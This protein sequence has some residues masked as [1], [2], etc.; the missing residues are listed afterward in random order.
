M[1]M[2]RWGIVEGVVSSR[3]GYCQGWGIVKGGV[4]S[5]WGIVGWGIVKGGVSSRW[6]IVGWGIVGG[7]YN[8]GK[9]WHAQACTPIEPCDSFL[10]I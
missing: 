10:T 3:V 8:L 1:K 9:I 4:K 5:R 2:L 7:T 6:G